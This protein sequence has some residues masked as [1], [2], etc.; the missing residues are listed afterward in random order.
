MAKFSGVSVHYISVEEGGK[1]RKGAELAFNNQGEG[2]QARS[3][4]F[5][6]GSFGSKLK[7]ERNV[8]FFSF[9]NLRFFWKRHLDQLE[10]KNIN[11]YRK[12]YPFIDEF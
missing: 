3:H 4:H 5:Q 11:L 7:G 1:G 10:N 2:K 8:F 9:F 12:V 6:L